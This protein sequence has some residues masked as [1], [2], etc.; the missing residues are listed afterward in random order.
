MALGYRTIDSVFVVAD[1]D[2]ISPFYGFIT[3][4]VS[5]FTRYPAK[6]TAVLFIY[7]TIRPSQCNITRRIVQAM[8]IIITLYHMSGIFIYV[9]QCTPPAAFWKDSFKPQ[10]STL[11]RVRCISRVSVHHGIP[12]ANSITTS[13]LCILLLS[14][15]RRFHISLGA[16]RT[17][18]AFLGAM[19]I[20]CFGASIS[21][22]LNPVLTSQGQLMSDPARSGAH[23][24]LTSMLETS[25]FLAAA[26][27]PSIRSILYPPLSTPEITTDMHALTDA[28]NH[29]HHKSVS[30]T[31]IAFSRPST[32]AREPSRPSFCPSS[33][34]ELH[35]APSYPTS[36]DPLQILMPRNK[37]SA[38]RSHEAS[39]KALAP[40]E[41]DVVAEAVADGQVVITTE[42][43][44]KSYFEPAMAKV[45]KGGWGI[46][47]GLAK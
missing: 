29:G 34:T 43:E 13:V 42:F 45:G 10:E 38:G 46:F 7:R 23:I 8:F 47:R 15:F 9:F 35:T 28:R 30:E 12:I 18:W 20:T 14:V 4:I 1:A 41:R 21:S 2:I 36:L 17:D 33:C 25:L 31:S 44:M 32:T 24:S 19:Y 11:N 37:Y 3:H 27:I 22:I 16:R 39:V 5:E 6:I 40:E 26:S